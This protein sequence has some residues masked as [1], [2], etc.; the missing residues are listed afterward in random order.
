M[1]CIRS[2]KETR[3]WFAF[4][5]TTHKFSKII[6]KLINSSIQAICTLVLKV[7][8]KN[9]ISDTAV[10]DNLMVCL[11]NKPTALKYKLLECLI[12][13]A[14]TNSIS[15][16]V[17]LASLFLYCGHKE[18][19]SVYIAIGVTKAGNYSLWHH[20]SS[21]SCQSCCF[22]SCLLLNSR[23][24]KHSSFLGVTLLFIFLCCSELWDHISQEVCLP[25]QEMNKSQSKMT[26]ARHKKKEKVRL[27]KKK[28]S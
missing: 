27:D 17:S 13:T 2:P 4:K 11:Q 20:D 8:H 16:S 9:G 6:L 7:Q 25:T 5:Y 18:M 15:L 1:K 24:R 10:S 21:F 22:L 19:L 23:S 12:C 3:R 28:K 14:E 26:R